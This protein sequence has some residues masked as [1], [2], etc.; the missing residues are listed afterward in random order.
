MHTHLS[1]DNVPGIAEADVIVR[2]V[3]AQ[4]VFK[5]LFSILTHLQKSLNHIFF[6]SYRA[7]VWKWRKL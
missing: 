2:V 6:T 3:E 1:L 5:V 7:D 4:A